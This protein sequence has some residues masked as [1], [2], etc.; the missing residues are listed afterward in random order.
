MSRDNSRPSTTT[1]CLPLKR[2]VLRA[3]GIYT[4]DRDAKRLVLS[5]PKYINSMLEKF[6]FGNYLLEIA[7]ASN[8]GDSVV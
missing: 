1:Q 5:Q 4:R 2:E 7:K 3:R 8:A 6:G